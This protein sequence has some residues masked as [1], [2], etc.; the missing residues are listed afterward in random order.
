MSTYVAS[1]L[2][3]VEITLEDDKLSLLEVLKKLRLLMGQ[4][5]EATTASPVAV[6]A[7]GQLAFSVAGSPV[8]EDELEVLGL[9][10]GQSGRRLA[11]SSLLLRGGLEEEARVGDGVQESTKV[12][13]KH[14]RDEPRDRL[15]A[16]NDLSSQVGGEEE[17]SKDKVNVELET[18]VVE[19]KVNTALGLAGIASLLESLIGSGEVVDENVLLRLLASLSSLELLDIFVGEVG[20]QRQV[21][22]VTPE[23]DLEHLVEED[24]LGLGVVGGL[25]FVLELLNELLVASGKLDDSIAGSTEGVQLLTGEDVVGLPVLGQGE[26][27]A[28]ALVHVALGEQPGDG[29]P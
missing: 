20:Q 5:P 13:G 27:S 24:L 3:V 4:S 1:Q 12:G 22:G 8:L 11:L 23:A 25:I 28:D 9:A 7:D 16:E 14:V 26:E 10:I 17:A 2:A 29:V 15:G 6:G 21:S 18:G 19:D